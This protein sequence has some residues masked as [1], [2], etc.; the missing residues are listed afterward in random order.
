M[1]QSLMRDRLET[2]EASIREMHSTA[3]IPLG[4]TPT[5]EELIEQAK[6]D[7]AKRKL[8]EQAINTMEFED[9]LVGFN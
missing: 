9:P 4:D 3:A 6:A 7:P 8:F 1:E 5:V 2:L